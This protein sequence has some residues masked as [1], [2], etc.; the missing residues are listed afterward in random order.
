M[1]GSQFQDISLESTFIRLT[2]KMN[3]ETLET[4]SARRKFNLELCSVHC[5]CCVHAV[6]KSAECHEQRCYQMCDNS[7]LYMY[8]KNSVFPD[9]LIRLNRKSVFFCSK[10]CDLNGLKF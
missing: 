7:P 3:N 6:C 5:A 2:G 4:L 10:T 9:F 1:E 8:L